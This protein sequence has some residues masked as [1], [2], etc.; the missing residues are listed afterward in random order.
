MINDIMSIFV[1]VVYACRYGIALT[2][3]TVAI[4]LYITLTEDKT[5][6]S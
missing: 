6:D 1:Y 3:A 4:I 2:M 5:T